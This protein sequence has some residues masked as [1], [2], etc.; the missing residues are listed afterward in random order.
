MSMWLGGRC[1]KY[2]VGEDGKRLDWKKVK[3]WILLGENFQT[4]LLGVT[5]SEA[6]PLDPD[7]RESALCAAETCSKQR[8]NSGAAERNGATTNTTE[9]PSKKRRRNSEP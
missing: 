2:R 7:C 6:L 1:R 3:G 4:D 5:V 8:R 9:S